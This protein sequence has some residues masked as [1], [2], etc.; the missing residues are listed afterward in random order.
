MGVGIDLVRMGKDLEV[1]RQVAN[2]KSEK[3][4]TRH[5]HRNFLADGRFEENVEDIHRV[6]DLMSGPSPWRHRADLDSRTG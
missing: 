3:Y 2:H 1:S 6:A 5:R 4:K